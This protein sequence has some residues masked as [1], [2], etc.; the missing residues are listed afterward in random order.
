MKKLRPLRQDEIREEL[1][2]TV[3]QKRA[4]D[5][6]DNLRSRGFLA[7]RKY[8]SYFALLSVADREPT[9]RVAFVTSNDTV[10]KKTLVLGEN[11]AQR[12]FNDP[13]KLDGIVK[14]N[15]AKRIVACYSE[16]DGCEDVA[17]T[18]EKL[19]G[20]YYAVKSAEFYDFV[21]IDGGELHSLIR[22]YKVDHVFN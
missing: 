15:K 17:Y 4:D 8:L 7:G 1:R 9:L 12:M 13:S 18:L 20:L 3:L 19:Q 21:L 10:R 11:E 5:A 22:V 14:E 6:A 16:P 2:Q